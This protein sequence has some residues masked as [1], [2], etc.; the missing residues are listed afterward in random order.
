MRLLG[1]PLCGRGEVRRT[2]GGLN[3]LWHMGLDYAANVV[4]MYKLL[5]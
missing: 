2:R 4:S 3:K 5:P 1:G